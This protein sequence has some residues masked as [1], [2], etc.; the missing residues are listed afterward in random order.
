MVQRLLCGGYIRGFATPDL[1]GA[2]L[3]GACV[4]ECERPRQIPPQIVHGI[5]MSGGLFVGLTA[6]QER[7]AQH[8]GR[9]GV[10]Q[11][12]H[13]VLGDLGY[14][15]ALRA[16]EP[17]YHH[18]WFEDHALK[19]N[20]LGHELI[21][22]RMQR[23][24][25]DLET[26]FNGVIAVDQHLR[27]HNG[28]Q[29]GF[30]SQCGV[31]RQAVGIGLDASTTGDTFSDGNDGAPLGEAGAH[32]FVLGEPITQTVEAFG[33]L[34]RGMPSQVLRPLVHLDSGNDAGV[35]Q[36]R[37]K[38]CAV[39]RLLADGFVEQDGCTDKFRKPVY[40]YQHIPVCLP[41]FF[42]ARNA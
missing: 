34:F 40:G 5:Q 1:H 39:E 14:P 23:F 11:A 7:H 20:T 42:R 36:A 10:Q 9:Y 21:E 2:L 37:G 3:Q 4:R 35:R 17:R 18:A 15:R 30:L 25:G 33:H 22:Y 26:A 28:N 16:V 24:L 27:F 12:A 38:R 19:M 31:P 13:R 8:S 41:V 29:A 32:L 6:R